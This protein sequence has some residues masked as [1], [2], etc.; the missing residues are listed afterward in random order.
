MTFRRITA[1]PAL[2]VMRFAASRPLLCTLQ[3]K[4]SPE[5]G[6]VSISA[7]SANRYLGCILKLLHAKTTIPW[8]LP[9]WLWPQFASFQEPPLKV[10][11]SPPW[12][13][14]DGATT[15]GSAK[16]LGCTCQHTLAIQ[17]KKQPYA[18][19]NPARRIIMLARCQ[20]TNR[21]Y[22]HKYDFYC[23]YGAAAVAAAVAVAAASDLAL[24][25]A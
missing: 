1:E 14:V 9:S 17:H 8:R 16:I 10:R 24:P 6:I 13:Q 3:H 7:S 20:D 12:D 18:V 23:D 25:L 5:I 4:L 2:R 19:V 21:G 22:E 15:P 11:R